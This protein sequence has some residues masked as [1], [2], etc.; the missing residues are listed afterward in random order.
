[1]SLEQNIEKQHL[2]KLLGHRETSWVCEREML[3]LEQ[4][5]L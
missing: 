2:D 5:K 1:M 4:T 3:G